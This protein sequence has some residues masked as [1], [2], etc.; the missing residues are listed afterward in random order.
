MH[1][2]G[3]WRRDVPRKLAARPKLL[4]Q[5]WRNL[6]IELSTPGFA[7]FSQNWT[8]WKDV[9]TWLGAL[10]PGFYPPGAAPAVR[11]LVH[12]IATGPWGAGA[13]P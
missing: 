2:T 10:S 6:K 12:R 11:G 4:R 1:A 7:R 9:W 3:I 5:A 13:A 8:Y